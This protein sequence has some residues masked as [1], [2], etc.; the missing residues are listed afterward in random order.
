MSTL[1]VS[2][3]SFLKVTA[4]AG[5]GLMLG[6]HALAK[7]TEESLAG[8]VFAPNAFLK[9]DANGIV[10]L[11]SPNPEVG[12]GIKTSMPMLVAEELEADWT[13]VVV[14]QTPLNTT[15]Y[16]RQVAGGSGSI[17]S[18]WEPFRKAGAAARQKLVEAGARTWRLSAEE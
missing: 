4:L 5:G 8:E 9:I 14:E 15:L 2:R 1:T 6:F 7:N 10:T 16:T 17:R 3:R 12:Q 13:K 18:S 11:M